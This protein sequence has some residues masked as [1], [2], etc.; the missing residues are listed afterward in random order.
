MTA[1]TNFGNSSIF[2]G[3]VS[4]SFNSQPIF[5]GVATGYAIQV[6]GQTVSGTISLQASADNGFSGSVIDSP[7]I[8][9][10]NTITGTSSTIS[11]SSSTLYNVSDAYYPWI[12]IAYTHVV[13]GGTLEMIYNT[14]KK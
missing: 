8:N 9:N 4:A 10:W 7:V 13:G 12:R 11:G 2:S 3:S 6:V 1:F 5:I 14:G